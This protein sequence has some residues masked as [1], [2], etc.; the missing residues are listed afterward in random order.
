MSSGGGIMDLELAR[1]MP[2]RTI[3]S[4]PA[5]GVAG[6]LW[7]ARNAGLSDFITCDMGGTSTDVCLIEDLH[8]STVSETAF[9]GYPIKGRE[10]AINTVG[11]G[12]GSVAFV[13]RAARCRW[14]RAVRVPSPAPRAT[15]AA[16]PSPPSRTPTS[17]SGASAPRVLGGAIRPD[18]RLAREAVAS[19]AIAPR[20]RERRGDGRGHRAHRRRADGERDPRD[21]ARARLRPVGLRAVPVRRRRAHA[22]GADRRGDRHPRDPGADP[23]REPVGPGPARL[24]P[25]LRARAVVHGPAVVVRREGLRR[26]ARRA[27]PQ[28][29]RRPRAPRLRERVDALQPCRSTCA[30]SGRRSSS[31]SSFPTMPAMRSACARCSSTPTHGSSGARIPM[32]RSRS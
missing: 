9:A 15:A 5:G 2:V 3:L 23:A 28:R 24:G 25:A 22:R 30:T 10:I 27:R 6:A 31:R 21:L 12:G 26:R 20:C 32:R 16:E 19:L 11:A 29:K 18:P 8:A 4:G 17:C 1:R 7:I 14:G 13:D